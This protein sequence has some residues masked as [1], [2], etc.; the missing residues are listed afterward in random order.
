MLYYWPRISNHYLS[1][2]CETISEVKLLIKSELLHCCTSQP[3]LRTYQWLSM[4]I[5]DYPETKDASHC[6]PRLR[7]D[8]RSR[9]CMLEFDNNGLFW[10]NG[11]FYFVVMY[12]IDIYFYISWFTSG[13]RNPHYMEVTDFVVYL[14][15]NSIFNDRMAWFFMNIQHMSYLNQDV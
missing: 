11:I 5:N 1:R 14:S 7:S 4:I 15:E 10:L 13:H 8:E 3:L 6:W 2:C 9:R 12:A